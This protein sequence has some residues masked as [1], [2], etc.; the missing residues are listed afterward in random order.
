M[1]TLQ[2]L[3][4]KNRFGKH[5]V[6]WISSRSVVVPSFR[7]RPPGAACHHAPEGSWQLSLGPRFNLL[8]GLCQPECNVTTDALSFS[9]YIVMMAKKLKLL[10]ELLSKLLSPSIPL[11]HPYNPHNSSL[12]NPL[13][14][15]LYRS[16]DY[17]SYETK[18][19][20]LLPKR[21]SFQAAPCNCRNS[22]MGF[23]ISH[24]IASFSAS[25]G[26]SRRSSNF[27]GLLLRNLN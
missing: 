16:L 10:F 24:L 18:G 7:S 13:Y 19:P 27:S 5:K 1:E 26:T 11:L 20:P 22:E 15:P 12:G 21:C 23:G 8:S 17:S 2:N 6:A 3:A 25:T 14:N 9:E 4:C